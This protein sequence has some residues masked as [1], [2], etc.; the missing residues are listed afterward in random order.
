M[1]GGGLACK[2]PG[3]LQGGGGGWLLQPVLRNLWPSF[4]GAQPCPRI[5]AVGVPALPAQAWVEGS[6]RQERSSRP[7]HPRKVQLVLCVPLDGTGRGVPPEP[8]V[9]SR[10]A[11]PAH[12]RAEAH[13]T[14]SGGLSGVERCLQLEPLLLFTNSKLSDANTDGGSQR[15]MGGPPGSQASVLGASAPEVS[16]APEMESCT[17]G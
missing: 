9:R 5:P 11:T 16:S 13:G 3:G 8:H 14:G 10:R 2:S 7:S 12:G 6:W 1:G 15:L 4:L 17:N